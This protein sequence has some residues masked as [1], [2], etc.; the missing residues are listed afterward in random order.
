MKIYYKK[1]GV[2]VVEAAVD[3]THNTEDVISDLLRALSKYKD[4]TVVSMTV[5]YVDG[6]K[7]EAV[8]NVQTITA[9]MVDTLI[10]ELK[11]DPV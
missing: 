10:V 5:K 2:N 9:D 1:N 3:G 4:D 7:E 8:R 6:I 11:D